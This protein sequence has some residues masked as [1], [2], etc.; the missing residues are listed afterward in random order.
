MI[1]DKK[2]VRILCLD[3][4]PAPLGAY[5]SVLEPH[6]YEVV[7]TLDSIEALRIMLR[8]PVDL[9][10][11]DLARPVLNG[12]DLYAMMKVNKRLQNIP[13][14]ICSG[15]D[16]SLR[17]FLD[18]YTDVEGALQKPFDVQYLLD[19]VRKA[20]GSTAHQRSDIARPS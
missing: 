5:K 7:T 17:K 6:G 9:F 8:E 20:L 13:V 4:E 2:A 18:R 14:V 1:N 15:H 19:V 16:D 3:D 12:F 10:I 11:Q